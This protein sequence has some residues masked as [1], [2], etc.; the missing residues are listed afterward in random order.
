MRQFSDLPQDDGSRRFQRCPPS[1]HEMALTPHLA[2]AS[3]RAPRPSRPT[4]PSTVSSAQVSPYQ[5]RGS[6]MPPDPPAPLASH[7]PHRS[8]VHRSMGGDCTRARS[9]DHSCGSLAPTPT[10]FG[11]STP[12]YSPHHHVNMGGGNSPTARTPTPLV[13]VTPSSHPT[14]IVEWAARACPEDV[15]E[16]AHEILAYWDAHATPHEQSLFWATNAG[17]PLSSRPSIRERLLANARTEV[18][19]AQWVRSYLAAMST[20][21]SHPHRHKGGRTGP[22]APTPVIP[23]QVSSPSTSKARPPTTPARSTKTAS[24]QQTQSSSSP[25][26]AIPRRGGASLAEHRAATVLQ[27][28]KR[29]IW[30]R[31]WFDQQALL[32]QKR[33]RLQALCRGASSYA[34]SVRGNRRPTP[35]PTEKSSD[36]KVLRHPFRT[37]GQPLPPRKR[38]RR[39]KR[40]RRRPGR[41]HRPRAPDSGGGPSC[42]PLFF[43]AA[44][45]MAASD[46]L[47]VGEPILTI[48]MSPTSAASKIQYAYRHH[49]IRRNRLHLP[50]LRGHY[51]SRP[52]STVA[53]DEWAATMNHHYRSKLASMYRE[54]APLPFAAMISYLYDLRRLHITA[55]PPM[56]SDY[57]TMLREYAVRKVLLSKW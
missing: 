51:T 26:P 19:R 49:L 11:A 30:L 3:A 10:S 44:Q 37:R 56:S 17:P 28:W 27:C 15:S 41:R 5:Q 2:Q 57:A 42:M 29:R 52:G 40:P 33:L 45:T 13:G 54:W 16:D 47:G 4:P 8:M 53:T 32:K 31:R 35:A 36:P 50:R 55:W 39:H 9:Y 1:L 18:R 25:S 21:P 14:D 7:P 38:G 24:P 23:P 46:L 6:T 48:Y 20:S 43:W 12:T 22:M 34:S